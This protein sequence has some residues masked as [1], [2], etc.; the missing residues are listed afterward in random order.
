MFDIDPIPVCYGFIKLIVLD[1]FGDNKC[2]INQVFLLSEN[3]DKNEDTT[4]SFIDARSKVSPQGSNRKSKDEDIDD[5]LIR[6]ITGLK[7]QM[8]ELRGHNKSL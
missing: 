7:E 5:Y 8:E 2:Y 1:S 3:P 6:E 4:Q